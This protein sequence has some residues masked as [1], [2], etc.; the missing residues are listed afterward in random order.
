MKHL[1]I[2]SI[3]DDAVGDIDNPIDNKC[4]EED[5]IEQ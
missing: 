3:V 4:H 5:K 1:I 2:L